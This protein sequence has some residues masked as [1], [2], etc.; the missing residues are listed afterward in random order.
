MVADLMGDHIGFG[1]IAGRAELVLELV[2]EGEIDIELLIAWA[3]ERPRGGAGEAAGGAG[4]AGEEDERRRAIGATGLLEDRGPV[5]LRVAKNLRNELAALVGRRADTAGWC[6]GG[7][8]IAAANDHG[9]AD[10][11]TA[12]AVEQLERVDAEQPHDA[13][14]DDN[15]EDTDTAAPAASAGG[16]AYGH[17]PAAEAARATAETTGAASLA[18]P[19]LD[20]AALPPTAQAHLCFSSSAADPRDGRNEYTP[21]PFPGERLSSAVKRSAGW[22]GLRERPRRPGADPSND[23]IEEAGK[24]RIEIVAAE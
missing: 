22:D 6:A 12:T 4:G 2:V 16:K 5:I 21:S 1:E 19:I 23:R 24:E 13:E 8:A 14:N 20:V 3:V 10:A 11:A 15:A 18:A 17:P 7:C 9:R